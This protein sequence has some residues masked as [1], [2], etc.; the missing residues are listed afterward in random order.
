MGE[1]LKYVSG[2]GIIILNSDADKSRDTTLRR[3]VGL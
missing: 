3:P 1:G 2:Y